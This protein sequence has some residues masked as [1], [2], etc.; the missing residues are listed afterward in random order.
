[1]TIP[2]VDTPLP[3]ESYP[4]DEKAMQ[5]R[6]WKGGNCRL[7]YGQDYVQ[8]T[9]NRKCAYCGADLFDC[10]ERWLTMVL[11]HVVPVSVCK[12][13]DIISNGWCRSLANAVLACAA[14]NGF[15]NHYKPQKTIKPETFQ[16]FLVMRDEIFLDRK[17]LILRRRKE[18]EGRYNKQ[19][20]LIHP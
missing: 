17:D 3:F 5:Q 8:I 7:G 10:Y 2:D 9:R 12:Q 18:E 4:K 15:C 19:K 14:C 6:A 1:M 13:L 20:A 11:D 16:K